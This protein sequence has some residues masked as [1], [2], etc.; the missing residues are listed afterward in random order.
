MTE[1][2][3]QPTVSGR[4]NET[5]TSGILLHISSL[6]SPYGIGDFG[7][8]SRNFVDF[9]AKSGQSYWQVLPLVPVSPAFG[10]SP[11]MSGSAFAGN[12]LL[13]SP[14]LLIRDGWLRQ[15]ELPS[16]PGEFS[17]YLVN[18]EAVT[19]WKDKVLEL[20][21]QFFL[22]T[23]SADQQEAFFVELT[24]RLPWLRDYS[25]FTALKQHFGQKGWFDWPEELRLH[26]PEAVKTAEQQLQQA[27][28]RC[29]F[30]QY[31]FFQQWE[32]LHTYAAAQGVQIIG[33]LPIYVA[34]DSADVWADQDIFML[35]PKKT[36]HPTHV[37]GV[38]PDY[39]SKTGQLWG[40]P[41]YRWHSRSAEVKQR[42]LDWWEQRLRAILSVVDVIRID[43][44]RG[45]EAYW[46][47]PAK[48]ETAMNGTWQKGPG[49]R[50]FKEMEKRIGALPVIAE[51]L[52]V[53]TPEMEALRDDLG[54][55]G[56]KILLFAFNGKADNAYLPH[57][58]INNCVV[59]TGTHDNDTA[60]GWYLSGEVPAAAKRQA[61]QYANRC[62][63]DAS[64]FHEDLLYLAQ[65]SP[66]ALCILPMQDV[67]GFGN[68]CRMNTPG[69]A[70]GNWR[71]R[72]APRFITDALAARLQQ[73]TALFG[74]L[75]T[76][77]REEDKK[78]A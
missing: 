17:E 10:N 70:S 1:Q 24:D 65:S 71:W 51:D 63:D 58:M 18:F 77:K 57:N 61:K 76:K 66:A 39:F 33:D 6:P 19:V 23:K 62:D 46:A 7:P 50:F 53:I 16:L 60:V 54:F 72:C 42:L 34:L 40:N 13:I 37:A 31:L 15:E 45:F 35:S 8:A 20:A 43:H 26:Q 47:V 11:Y 2:T 5:R 3:F 67:L 41:L 75:P 36:G 74:R 30:E 68:D 22:Q 52:G 38:P 12:P 56:M 27:V 25:L 4:I 78:E 55:P 49:I 69:T 48:D 32:E 9:L 29:Q 73:S 28:R 21:W 59:Y 44:F 14:E 64:R